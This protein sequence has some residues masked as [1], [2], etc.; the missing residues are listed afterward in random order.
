MRAENIRMALLTAFLLMSPAFFLS[1]NDATPKEDVTDAAD[2]RLLEDPGP[3][4]IWTHY[5][6]V[7]I[8]MLKTVV[9]LAQ[10][11]MDSAFWILQFPG[12]IPV[13]AREVLGRS[14][15]DV[16]GYLPD[17]AYI[18]RCRNGLTPRNGLIVPG[19]RAAPYYSGL[20]VHPLVY[21]EMT[22]R[23]GTGT[24]QGVSSLLVD[25]F[26][27]DE[28]TFE[29]IERAA[30]GSI[31]VS[32]TRAL[33]PLPASDLTGLLRVDGVRSIEPLYPMVLMNNVSSRIIDVNVVRSVNGLTGKG[34]MVGISDTG[35]DTG[36]DNHS[37]DGDILADF[38]NRV[39][40]AN[41]AG[42]S[43]D[44]AHSHGTH[45]AGSVA[46]NGSLS[47]G[48]IVGMA[49]EA[50]IF[51]QG[52]ADD[53]HVLRVPNNLSL[54]F[55]QA[56]DNG[57]RIHTNSW[58]A[59][60]SGLYTIY[61]R[62]VDWFLFNYPDM[63]I[64]YSAGNSGI[65]Y[66]KPYGT[67]DP[68]GKIDPDSIGAP[69]TAKSCITVGASESYRLDGGLQV[70]WGTGSWLWKYS[71]DPI[72]TDKPSDDP[73]GLAAFSSRG[74]TDDGRIKPDVVAPG[75]NI[76]STKSTKTSNTGWGAF[77]QNSNY[78]YMGGTSM[79]CPITAGATALIREYYN[80][81]LG[82]DSPSGALMK[83]TLI[84]GAQDMTPGQYGTSNPVTQE[85]NSRPDNDQGWGRINITNSLYPHGKN[86]T[87]MDMK[88]GIR[89]G[90]NLTFNF[91]VNGGG[92]LNATLVWSDFPAETSSSK[93]LVN[94]LDLV[95]IA[96]NGTRYNGNDMDSP[97]GDV[98]DRTNPV[99]GIQIVD[100]APG[101]WTVIV[102]GH[103]IPMGPQHFA[104]VA[105]GDA[106]PFTPLVRMDMGYYSTDGDE[107]IIDVVDGDR[108]GAGTLTVNVSSDT[109]P[110]GRAVTLDEIGVSG[111][112]RGYIKTHNA[113]TSNSSLLPVSN[114]DEISVVHT[115]GGSGR[116]EA[117][118]VAK[119]PMRI[120]LE[121]AP[122]YDLVFSE[123]EVL[124]LSGPGQ[125]GIDAEWTLT[126]SGIG[127]QGIYDD[128]NLS[129]G[130]D[131]ADDG[132]YSAL[133][134][135]P[136]MTDGQFDIVLRVNDP[137]LGVRTYGFYTLRFNRSIPRFPKN[138]S[139]YV[140][141]EG[142]T[143]DLSWSG[144]NETDLSH[145]SVMMTTMPGALSDDPYNW[146]IVHNTTGLQYNHTVKN[147]TDGMVYGLR[148]MVWD[149][150]GNA[151]SPSA[152]LWD[153]P[154][155]TLP[156]EV[157][158]KTDPYVIVGIG[159]LE[160]EGD[161][162]L[163]EVEV[164]YYIDT[165]GNGYPDDGG[166]FIP[167][168]RGPP[169][170]VAWD[171]RSEHG[172]PGDVPFLLLRFRGSDEVPNVSPFV[173][174]SGF[175]VDNTGPESVRLV[176]IPGRV[177]NESRLVSS[178]ESEPGGWVH[179]FLNGA[180]VDNATVDGDGV[181][182]VDLNLSE[183]VNELNLSSYDENGAGPTN[184]SYAITVDTML[185]HAII[186][187]GSTE[188]EIE[189]SLE[190]L[191]LRSFSM[192]Q[193]VDPEFTYLENI[194][195]T[196]IEPSGRRTDRYGSEN[197]T[198]IFEEF[199][200]HI[201]YLSVRDPAGNTNITYVLL[202]V[203]DTTPP[204]VNI[205]GEFEIDEDQTVRFD[206]EGTIDNDPL[207]RS[208]EGTMYN[209]TFTGA[210]SWTRTF[211]TN[212]VFITF[213]DPGDYS[214]LLVVTDGSNNSAHMEREIFVRDITP[215]Q[216]NII[217]PNS[218]I[219]GIP[220]TYLENVTDNDPLFPEGMTYSWNLTY[221]EGLPSEQWSILVDGTSIDHNF[222]VAGTYFL[223][224]TVTDR[225]GNRN[226]IG[227]SIIAIGDITPPT[228]LDVNPR[229]NASWQFPEDQLFTVR[230]SE[231]MHPDSIDNTTIYLSL[232]GSRIDCT[233]ELKD[234]G[235]RAVITH[236]PLLNGRTYTLVVETSVM[237]MWENSLGIGFSYDY[238]IRTVFSLVHP[239][240]VFPNSTDVNFSHTESVSLRFTNPVTPSS[241]HIEIR[242]RTK[243]GYLPVTS[244]V[245]QGDDERT[246]LVTGVFDEGATYEITVFMDSM[247]AFGYELDKIYIWEFK[248]YIP[249][250]VVDPEEEPEVD[251]DPFW[252]TPFLFVG[253]AILIVLLIIIGILLRVR[254]NRKLKRMWMEGNKDEEAEYLRRRQEKRKA[255]VQ[256]PPSQEGILDYDAVSS[257]PRTGGGSF[258]D[259]QTP[260][261][262]EE[263]PG[264]I[265]WDEPQD[266]EESWEE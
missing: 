20:K 53:G 210:G 242:T 176:P 203:Q 78:I 1:G 30:K 214:V 67:Y 124:R 87:F 260:V 179:I 198:L 243:E 60:Y 96:P 236:P 14:G 217:G 68:D 52:I 9:P 99:E 83:A 95:L 131:T 221:M 143:I 103:S 254:H 73:R 164:E 200:E 84:N 139:A 51:F 54:L 118:A 58:G 63:I 109:L 263:G 205:T 226:D 230:F 2:P 90:E 136:P 150:N 107:L 170:D 140:R 62:D 149:V 178:G 209:W 88:T 135:T 55:K 237:D 154:L 229:P 146:T 122:E 232:D 256:E 128:G 191:D 50:S 27:R 32:D 36:V 168:G 24:I 70:Q 123:Y 93:Q 157:I 246:L 194:T 261:P 47:N 144:S 173:F 82:L 18:I 216:G 16:M 26:V 224:L 193:G 208:R 262:P 108:K 190:G 75:T 49:P 65:D 187:D 41:W 33:V 57:T 233:V 35:L 134:T 259:Y 235:T 111:L 121:W 48:T 249:P 69:A 148:V 247:D 12:V 80:L 197:V 40:F 89:T 255:Q 202:T 71:K 159:H 265:D 137:Y 92:H 66:Y 223:T 155:D 231:E 156:P 201:L 94:D 160:F 183:G 158:L 56:Y 252:W 151:S 257:T 17:N 166:E 132:N 5:G 165:D 196:L 74:P 264:G 81:S 129:H 105:T 76:L 97:Y 211:D 28:D 219:L 251:R 59:A 37:V 102:S 207:F 185:P 125:K 142:N 169:D 44:D 126:G 186:D 175:E 174:S 8:D 227:L 61:S 204:E 145:Y 120:L 177:T 117:K 138:L 106:T 25:L 167:I 39:K 133:W 29:A 77:S 234:L 72:L 22:A 172:G 91:T 113:T 112:F 43:P 127:W 199:G 188:R 15:Y 213:Q 64:L 114:D 189:V 3:N 101:N 45:V 228:I 248:T 11:D 253:L 21:G 250:V 104:L 206:T 34:Q 218:P 241:V 161:D 225:T 115:F 7:P 152:P 222:T 245:R 240:G 116:A 4:M 13:D 220:V 42:T 184:A 110:V 130:D 38:D 46:G 119:T 19:T 153:T 31:R 100:P 238:T 163:M 79:S 141:P 212:T 258:L 171:T 85:I 181:F 182:I 147:L 180:L 244:S 215:P 192:D 98:F 266:D 10:S 195:W 162:D 6:A 23:P 86:L 239:D